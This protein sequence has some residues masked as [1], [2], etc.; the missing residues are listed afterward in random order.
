MAE[1]IGTAIGVVGILGQLFD[2]CV[3]AYGY[4]T[5]ATHLDTD[6]KRLL[7]KVRIEEMRLVVWG[8]E[9][10]VAEGKLEAHLKTE[11]NPQM[12]ALAT[13]IMTEL[14]N[15]VTDFQRLQERYG[16][17][18][19][20]TGAGTGQVLGGQTVGEPGKS[21][22]GKEKGERGGKE[23]SS[24]SPSKKGSEGGDQS[25]AQGR[26]H[27]R[28]NSRNGGGGLEKSFSWRKEITLRT[29]WVIA[30]TESSS[31][32]PFLSNICPF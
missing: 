29:K 4:F 19:Q 11:S 21:G 14:F 32:F 18:D 27:S 30:G 7:C 26:G 10:G 24:P 15:T 25:Q 1:I 16:L 28:K 9:W 3:K 6:S 8:R 12:K 20:S 22:N 17:V 31:L 5:T 2:G 13:Q 23:E